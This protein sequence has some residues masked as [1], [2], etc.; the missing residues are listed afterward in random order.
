[1][2]CDALYI[3][4]HGRDVRCLGPMQALELV[5]DRCLKPG[6]SEKTSDA[7]TIFLDLGF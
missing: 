5:K 1:M 4:L 6:V 7:V 2:A 3:F